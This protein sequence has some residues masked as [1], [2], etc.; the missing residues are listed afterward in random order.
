MARPGQTAQKG[1]VDKLA[2]EAKTALDD[3]TKKIEKN[4]PSADEIVQ[5]LNQHTQTAA[6]QIQ[7]FVNKLKEEGK[8]HEGE[9]NSAVK[10]AQTKLQEIA[11][12]LE[13]AVGP[14]ATATAKQIQQTFETNLDATV[15]E[16][17]KLAKEVQPKLK[18]KL[19]INEII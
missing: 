18:G 10:Q 12:N 7:T 14:K 11:T 6:T 3:L 2:S 17:K 5:T 16:F 1:S 19:T 9:V 4:T 15:T 8:A 13:N